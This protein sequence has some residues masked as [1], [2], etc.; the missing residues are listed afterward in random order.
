MARARKIDPEMAV[1]AAMALF[2]QYGYGGL[3]TRQLEEETGITRFTLQT[4]YGGKMALFLKALDG[5][6]DAFEIQGVPDMRDGNLDTIAQWF[7]DRTEP[8]Q[9]SEVACFGCL[10]L[11]SIVEFS[12][13]NA[14]VNA[15]TERFYGFV[16]GG[17]ARALE[18]VKAQGGVS[19]DFDVEAHAEVCL[20]VAI[21]QNAIIR[22]ATDNKAGV[23]MA[24]G[25][26][27]VIRTWGS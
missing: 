1:P 17:F 25:I 2:W 18:V 7:E 8:K 16:R 6:L 26:G 5:Y 20:G 3:G 4:T 11:N 22:S 10:M 23:R 12:G 21:S 27:S 15:Q 14:D 19:A 24:R 13:G 9:F